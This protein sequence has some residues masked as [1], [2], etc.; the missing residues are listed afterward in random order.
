[1]SSGRSVQ[2]S[3]EKSRPASRSMRFARRS[4]AGP[5]SA[6]RPTAAMFAKRGWLVTPHGGVS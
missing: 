2:R 3:A 5:S 6:V 1:M 4:S